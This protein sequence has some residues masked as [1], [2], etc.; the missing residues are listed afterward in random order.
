MRKR[1]SI[2]F[3]FQNKLMMLVSPNMQNKILRFER[4]G[5][6]S[7]W[8]NQSAVFQDGATSPG[9]PVMNSVMV[10]SSSFTLLTMGECEIITLVSGFNNYRVTWSFFPLSNH[11]SHGTASYPHSRKT[12]KLWLKR[13][14]FYDRCRRGYNRE[15]N[16]SCA[17][18]NLTRYHK[19][20]QTRPSDI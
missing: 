20:L 18:C 4:F 8:S 10:S 7:L 11:P 12:S 6:L 5:G 15:G 2:A 9:S 3:F 17:M 16:Q 14:L 1:R 19:I 13:D